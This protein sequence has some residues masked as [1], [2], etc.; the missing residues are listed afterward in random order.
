MLAHLLRLAGRY[1]HQQNP[2]P[3]PGAPPPLVRRALP[4]ADAPDAPQ[5][6]PWRGDGGG[7]AGAPGAGGDVAGDDYAPGDLDDLFAAVA[8]E[9]E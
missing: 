5:A 6:L 7:D 2:G 4:P 8:A 3:S 9:Q 1:E